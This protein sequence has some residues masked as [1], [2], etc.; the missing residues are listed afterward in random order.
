MKVYQRDLEESSDGRSPNVNDWR[1]LALSAK[2]NPVTSCKSDLLAWVSCSKRMW[3]TCGSMV[4]HHVRVT[5]LAIGDILVSRRNYLRNT[6]FS[7]FLFHPPGYSDHT[8]TSV[9]E[10]YITREVESSQAQ[11]DLNLARFFI[12]AGIILLWCPLVQTVILDIKAVPADDY[13]WASFLSRLKQRLFIKADS[14]TT[15]AIR[16]PP[17]MPI[18]ALTNVVNGSGGEQSTSRNLT[19]RWGDSQG[20][21]HSRERMSIPNLAIGLGYSAAGGVP[22]G[23]IGTLA[24]M[25]SPHTPGRGSIN[26]VDYPFRIPLVH[27]FRA[28]E[29][30]FLTSLDILIPRPSW[31]HEEAEGFALGLVLRRLTGL[32]RLS[33]HADGVIQHNSGNY[34]EFG[35]M[36][37]P[38]FSTTDTGDDDSD[39]PENADMVVAEDG[40]VIYSPAVSGTRAAPSQS[41]QISLVPSTVTTTHGGYGPETW[42]AGLFNAL[43]IPHF[44]AAG[45][46]IESL[47]EQSIK[48]LRISVS[49]PGGYVQ[50]TDFDAY[51]AMVAPY[52]QR[53]TILEILI[54]DMVVDIQ[55][56]SNSYINWS[57]N[58][59]RAIKDHFERQRGYVSRLV[60]P[61]ATVI[62]FVV[63]SDKPDLSHHQSEPYRVSLASKAGASKVPSHG[64]PTRAGTADSLFTRPSPSASTPVN[65]MEGNGPDGDPF[66]GNMTGSA[67]LNETPLAKNLQHVYFGEYHGIP[68]LPPPD[69]AGS[70]NQRMGGPKQGSSI[71]SK[72]PGKSFTPYPGCANRPKEPENK[73]KTTGIGVAPGFVSVKGIP[74]RVN[75]GEKEVLTADDGVN[76]E[77]PRSVPGM[78]WTIRP[79]SWCMGEEDLAQLDGAS[80]IPMKAVDRR[81]VVQGWEEVESYPYS[82]RDLT[83]NEEIGKG[84]LP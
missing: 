66:A 5:N 42:W 15:P 21:L 63:S 45:N 50:L 58:G 12:Q 6:Q 69:W 3:E 39:D 22:D 59:P 17:T 13:I 36:R 80:V 41:G 79:E 33:V 70:S 60:D 7:L 56:E 32:R 65:V 51:F 64:L 37:K 43:T 53:M 14:D 2:G 19:A 44:D 67:P 18:T 26:L 74:V 62:P 77:N 57:R 10:I 29:L 75:G 38:P 31:G 4:F 46:K 52:L 55:S 61:H 49:I 23:F 78:W 40:T 54:F 1:T 72:D 84:E 34:G 73:K 83:T 82:V 76:V 30:D 81:V 68:S 48:E 11:T 28:G 20:V 24:T 25:L 27:Y 71:P 35:L 16:T 9:L 47:H 8:P